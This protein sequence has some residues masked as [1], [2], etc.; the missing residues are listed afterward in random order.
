MDVACKL[1]SHFS[2]YYQNY[3]KF[4]YV[5]AYTSHCVLTRVFIDLRLTLLI[6]ILFLLYPYDAL[7]TYWLK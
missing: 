3:N 6:A 1:I 7:E 2:M 5:F 4:P